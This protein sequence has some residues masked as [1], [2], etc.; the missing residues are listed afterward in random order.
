MFERFHI[1]FCKEGWY[2]SNGRH[3]RPQMISW[4]TRREKIVS[5]QSYL[6]MS[7]NDEEE[8]FAHSRFRDHRVILTKRPHQL[9]HNILDI[10]KD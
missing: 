1:D 7:M 4:L 6:K 10:M 9:H 2:T 5:F 3:E 8:E